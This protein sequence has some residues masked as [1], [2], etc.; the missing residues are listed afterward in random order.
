MPG[1]PTISP[2]GPL[3]QKPKLHYPFQEIAVTS[4][5]TQDATYFLIVVD[6]WT[7]WPDFVHMGHDTTTV[8]FIKALLGAFRHT[9]TPDVVLSDEGPQFTPKHFKDFSKE[10]WF[11]YRTFLPMNPQSNGKAESTVKS[12]KKIIREAWTPYHHDQHKLTRVLLQYGTDHSYS[13]DFHQ[14]NI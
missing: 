1:S 10:W 6:C 13:T 7:D 9:R 8:Q 14:H 11:H 4:A 2:K 5:H 3:I 12:M